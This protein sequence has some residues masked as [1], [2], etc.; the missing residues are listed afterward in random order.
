MKRLTLT[1]LLVLCTALTPQAAPTS[2]ACNTC[3]GSGVCHV[4]EGSGEASSGG[5]CLICSGNKACYVCEG[6]GDF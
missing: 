3:E 5:T 6:S 2:A 1:L 4:C